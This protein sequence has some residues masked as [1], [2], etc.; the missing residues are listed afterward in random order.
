MFETISIQKE[1]GAQR[2][3]EYFNHLDLKKLTYINLSFSYI[4]IIYNLDFV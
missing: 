2:K 1:K 4:N 3:F